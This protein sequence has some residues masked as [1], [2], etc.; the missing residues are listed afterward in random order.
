MIGVV[1]V[2]EGGAKKRGSTPFPAM[3]ST[4]PC[5]VSVAL[6]AWARTHAS[7]KAF[8]VDLARPSNGP[9]RATSSLCFTQKKRERK[10]AWPCVSASSGEGEGNGD[11]EQLSAASGESIGP[12][13]SRHERPHGSG[14]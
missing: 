12:V 9:R 1:V 7:E 6:R 13:P 5:D 10:K 8:M 2:F 11:A 4:G 3:H 14:P